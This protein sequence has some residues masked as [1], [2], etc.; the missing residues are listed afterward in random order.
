MTMIDVNGFHPIVCN[1]RW[2]K[3]MSD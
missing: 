3:S 2:Q 1:S